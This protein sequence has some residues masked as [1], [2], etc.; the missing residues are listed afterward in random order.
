MLLP[1]LLSSQPAYL[2]RSLESKRVDVVLPKQPCQP[3]C[4]ADGRPVPE[5]PG[6][7]QGREREQGPGYDCKSF[8]HAQHAVEPPGPA[9]VG[10]QQPAAVTMVWAAGLVRAP[11]PS[12]LALLYAVC[13]SVVASVGALTVRNTAAGGPMSPR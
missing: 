10:L 3:R 4:E 5:P 12:P 8:E 6:G 7:R 11:A 1:P 13:H 9:D 2:E